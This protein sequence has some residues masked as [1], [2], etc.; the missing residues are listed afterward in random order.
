MIVEAVT[1][2]FFPRPPFHGQEL[3]GCSVPG[4]GGGGYQ[5]VVMRN[6]SD[7]ALLKTFVFVL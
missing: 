2:P 1:P 7:R 3:L 5:I 6:F 4:S